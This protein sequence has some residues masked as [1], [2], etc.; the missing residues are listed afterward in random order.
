LTFVTT[1]DPQTCQVA[2][3][4]STEQKNRLSK[5]TLKLVSLQTGIVPDAVYM[6]E[7]NDERMPGQSQG[8][9]TTPSDQPPTQKE[10]VAELP[11]LSSS[12]KMK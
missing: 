7:Q 12:C 1:L 5:G 9:G 10:T 2:T 6:P 3:E 11:G 4:Y 8:T